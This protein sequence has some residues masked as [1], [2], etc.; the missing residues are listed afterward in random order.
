VCSDA[1]FQAADV[2]K[3]QLQRIIEEYD[4]NERPSVR[5]KLGFSH[6]PA[7]AKVAEVLRRSMDED[8]ID[9]ETSINNIEE[10]WKDANNSVC[11]LSRC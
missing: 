9:L 11:K 1:D 6:K 8:I 4:Q 3:E 2:A 5:Q 10:E 7:K